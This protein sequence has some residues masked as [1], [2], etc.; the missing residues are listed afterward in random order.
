MAAVAVEGCVLLDVAIAVH[1]FGYH[2]QGRYHF[3]LAGCQKGP[4]T[5]SDGITLH[6]DAG[7]DALAAADTI[8][9][10]GYDDVR[11]PPP[12]PLLAAL[13]AAAARRARLISICTGAFALAHAG[14]LDGR[15][16]TTHWRCAALLAEQFPAVTVDPAVLY[17]DDGDILTSAGVAAG[18]DLCLHV[19]RRDH[20]A[21]AAAA[22]ARWSVVAPH[23]DGGQAQYIQ[24][25]IPG[26]DS[27][28]SLAATLAWALEHLGEPLTLTRLAQR[29][30]MS[31][32]TFSRRFRAETGTTPL[33]WLHAQRVTRALQLLEH[34][35]LP[36]T[37]IATACGFPGPAALRR[38][39]ARA[40]STT[41]AAYRRTF[42]PPPADAQPPPH[43]AQPDASQAR[44]HRTGMDDMSSLR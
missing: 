41:P 18:L 33:Q 31:P 39:L 20:G 24:R 6:A 7:L 26:P 27:T 9:I 19:V 15:R 35:D 13:R 28:R 32:R 12:G 30:R 34:T 21:A 37:A 16:A 23:R 43:P 5:T 25:P 42:R 14:V 29:A 11:A 22:I 10:A 4:V 3:T 1:V 44:P 40:T 38:H 8:I 36:I 17:V 2:G